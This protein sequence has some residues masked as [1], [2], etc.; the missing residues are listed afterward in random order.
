[1]FRPHYGKCIE[2]TN[3]GV[4]V[5]KKG[6][7]RQC[8]ERSKTMARQ[9]TKGNVHKRYPSHIPGDGDMDERKVQ[10]PKIF[11]RWER[12]SPIKVHKKSTGERKIFLE[13]WVERPHKCQC[14]NQALGD[15]PKTHFFSHLLSKGAYAVF[16]L[17]KLNI[18]L[19][20]F[21]CHHEWDYGDKTQDK[22]K[23]ARMIVEKLKRKYYDK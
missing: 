19:M 11:P 22:F 20:C 10:P 2:C 23:L 13:I 3:D 6:Y 12:K 7:C 8:N 18:M 1:M 21:D 15:E 4:I 16:R 17:I 5:V 9:S 14:C